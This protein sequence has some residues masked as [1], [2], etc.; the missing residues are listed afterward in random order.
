MSMPVDCR[1]IRDL[2]IRSGYEVIKAEVNKEGSCRLTLMD[3]VN[4]KGQIY[5]MTLRPVAPT[6]FEEFCNDT[7]EIHALGFGIIH[8]GTRKMPLSYDEVEHFT[9][10]SPE[11]REEIKKEYHYYL[12]GFWGT[13]VLIAAAAL[14]LTGLWQIVPMFFG[15]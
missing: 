1:K 11:N 13:R 14:W 7:T 3:L 5:Y 10:I 15:W 12:V 6:V 4:N 8:S 2:F 9:C